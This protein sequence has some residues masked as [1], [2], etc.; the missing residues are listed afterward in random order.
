MSRSRLLLLSLF[1]VLA[2][3]AVA[4]ASASA[5]VFLVGNMEI[6]HG[7]AF[8]FLSEQLSNAVLKST[9]ANVQVTCAKTLDHGYLLPLG[10][11]DVLVLFEE[12]SV[13]KPNTTCKV[14]EPIHI[15]ALDQLVTEEGKTLDNFVPKNGTNTF[16]VLHFTNC[17]LE[18]VEVEGSAR[19]DIQAL[20]MQLKNTLK[21]LNNAPAGLLTAAGSN[22]TFT[23]EED[24][25]LEND[26]NWGVID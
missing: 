21:F 4:S 5:L 10:H 9:G 17:S 19:A 1:A 25:W 3:S 20:T 24:V 22:A 23:L 13:Q 14:V 26:E 8:L 6:L 18:T 7:E 15:E 16:T 12:C 11:S 2:T